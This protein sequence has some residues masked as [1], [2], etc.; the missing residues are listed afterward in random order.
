MKPQKSYDDALNLRGDWSR[1]DVLAGLHEGNDA[2]LRD[3]LAALAYHVRARPMLARAL[4]AL[5]EAEKRETLLRAA[6]EA[7]NSERARLSRE[8]SEAGAALAKVREP[9]NVVRQ[10]DRRL[11]EWRT[12]QANANP[13][14][15]GEAAASRR[16]NA[17]RAALAN[18][19]PSDDALAYPSA[20]ELAERLRQLVGDLE[21][22]T[23]T[24]PATPLLDEILALKR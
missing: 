21:R 8:E 10:F 24:L 1:A 9:A 19:R 6:H 3:E 4:A 13:H 11:G 18:W 16:Y 12:V 15:G 5:A 14:A 20:H 23:A 22:A 17:A 2:T 7:A